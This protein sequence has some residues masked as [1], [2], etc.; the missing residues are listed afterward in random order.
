M[1]EAVIR[2]E[3]T[4]AA[5]TRRAVQHAG[6]EIPLLSAQVCWVFPC[7]LPPVMLRSLSEE[8][9]ANVTLLFWQLQRLTPADVSPLTSAGDRRGPCE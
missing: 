4:K 9:D 8:R 2:L 3:L 5:A 6:F 1:R 7:C